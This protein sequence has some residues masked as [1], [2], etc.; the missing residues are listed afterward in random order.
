LIHN[1]ISDVTAFSGLTKLKS[2]LLS[3]NQISDISGLSGLMNLTELRLI[4]N[5]IS[6]I[7]SL[8]ELT[9]LRCLH[10]GN[11]QI[12]DISALAELTNLREL[13][14]YQNH[15]SDISALIDLPVL[16]RL[17]LLGNSLNAAA[18]CA[19]LPLMRSSIPKVSN[20]SYDL[21]PHPLAGDWNGDCRVDL[22]DF[23][24]L[25]THWLQTGCGEQNNWCD[26][27]DLNHSGDVNLDDVAEFA[28]YLV[29]GTEQ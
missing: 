5:Q 12:S 11:N 27:A 9:N 10:L 23:A 24:V 16:D 2:L 17:C 19:Y 18:Y 13:F 28:N 8:A 22:V 14:L 21:N 7:S 3:H 4:H 1:Q 15:I 25:C 6:D 26:E 29:A 20:L